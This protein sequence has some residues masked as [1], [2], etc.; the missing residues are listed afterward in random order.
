MPYIT[1]LNLWIL[2]HSVTLIDL[3]LPLT[4][5]IGIIG[6]RKKILTCI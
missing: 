1:P 2:V 4:P 6:K 5:F 3:D